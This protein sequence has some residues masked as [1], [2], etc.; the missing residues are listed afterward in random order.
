MLQH[1]QQ[2]MLAPARRGEEP[3]QGHVVGLSPKNA[4]Q[5]RPQCDSAAVGR[6][7]ALTFSG[8]HA[9]INQHRA[10][11]RSR[12]FPVSPAQACAQATRHVLSTARAHPPGTARH[13]RTQPP[14]LIAGHSGR[15]HAITRLRQRVARVRRDRV[16]ADAEPGQMRCTR[17]HGGE[18]LIR[19]RFQQR[20]HLA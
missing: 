9:G 18:F 4:V 13:R 17:R 20:D 3:V 7:H 5:E 15:P 2:F 12:S 16:H 6:A 14:P 1:T 19:V 10:S 8:R 11:Y